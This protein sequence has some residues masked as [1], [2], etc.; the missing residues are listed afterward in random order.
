[1][2]FQ[3]KTL[4]CRMHADDIAELHFDNQG[5]A[6]NVLNQATLRE[7]DQAV[8]ALEAA[9]QVK[10]LLVTSG[11]SVFIVGADINEFLPTFRATPVEQ[12]ADWVGPAQNIFS[13]LEDLPFPSVAAINGYALGG[14]LETAMSAVYRVASTEAVVG[15]PEVKL[16]ILPGFGGTVRLP[17]LIGVDN[18]IE[19]IASGRDVKAEE[20]L[21][22]HLVQAVVAPER[23]L[24]AAE[25][26][27]RRA[28]RD[29]RWEADREVKRR[30]VLLN[31]IERIM[32][33][34]TAKGFVGVQ[35]G[36]NYPAPLE[37]I[38]TMEKSVAEDRTAAMRREAEAF[39]RL[40]KTPEAEGLIGI[41]LADQFIKKLSRQQSK[42]ARDV[43]RAA[44]LGAGIMGGGI[45]YQSARRGV[46]IFMKD[47]A[48]AAVQK[49]L[50]EAARLLGGQVER[51][52][53]TQ[54]EMADV[55]TRIQG[56]LSY[57]DF[58]TADVVIEAV[59][60]NPKIKKSV[61]KEVEKKVRPETIIATNTSTISIDI[62]AKALKDPTRF[63][64]M[65]FFNPVHRMPLVEVIRGS[66]S[67]DEAVATVVAYALKMGKTPIVVK[68]C[69]GFLV[70]RVLGPYMLA[71]QM[72]VAEGVPIETLDK[73]ME[74]FGWPM[75]PA[76]LHDVVG[77]DTAFHAGQV[78]AKAFPE[79]AKLAKSS[80][81]A[82][83]YKAGSFGQKNGKGFYSYAPD[84]K[85]RPQ[86]VFD[87]AVL[88]VLKPAIRG[89]KEG[90]SGEEIVERMMLPMIVEAS[91][92]LSDGIVG[93]PTEL[94][95]SLI[96][97]L[98]FP[99]FRGGLLKYAD[100]M[101][102]G[103][104]IKAA[105]RYAGYGALYRPTEQMRRL[106]AQGAGF[107]G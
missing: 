69:P 2:L 107:H 29:R 10:G 33:F 49:G 58:D 87:P 11:K 40:G 67:S 51:K 97:G 63:C 42:G 106:A 96:M 47:I 9:R 94:D 18:A 99:P 59:V 22:L 36:P 24:A 30:P 62:L 53:M 17:R 43:Q 55:L 34:T 56:T 95:M 60:E 45:A 71:F 77:L 81:V 102:L 26:L 6:V 93:T 48:P 15:Q 3:G 37:A 19:L 52:R 7:L 84:A 12:L 16:G 64:G 54:G 27:L 74:K 86:K 105:E 61:L 91:R 104:W 66:Q 39:A 13:R 31:G 70:N 90:M 80:P 82:V 78:M 14:G 20:A 101:G 21:K 46:P 76:Y 98:G 28:M 32:A 35:A 44:V 41:F 79:L 4:L 8:A 100:R 23:L 92:C 103:D 38:G 88:E 25:A 75:G 50:D 73:T 72:L 65:H 85:G 89:G 83:L 57:G 1:M 68:D 5:G